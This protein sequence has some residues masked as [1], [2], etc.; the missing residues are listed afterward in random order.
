[1]VLLWS[2]GNRTSEMLV[3]YSARVQN[4]DVERNWRATAP[5]VPKSSMT[6]VLVRVGGTAGGGGRSATWVAGRQRTSPL[7]AAVIT[8]YLWQR[9]R[10]RAVSRLLRYGRAPI[11]TLISIHPTFAMDSLLRT[12]NYY[13]VTLV[14]EYSHVSPICGLSW[15][16]H[17][18][19]V[20]CVPQNISI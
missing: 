5:A 12:I 15:L 20:L 16:H 3:E 8:V 13:D 14:C 4:P 18:G 11:L 6:S 2:C 1:M 9:G 7:P 10:G 19:L 17:S